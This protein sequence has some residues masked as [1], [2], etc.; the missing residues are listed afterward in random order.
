MNVPDC[1]TIAL[2]YSY[3][4]FKKTWVR[5]IPMTLHAGNRDIMSDA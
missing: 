2:A 3:C 4:S 1:T 5:I